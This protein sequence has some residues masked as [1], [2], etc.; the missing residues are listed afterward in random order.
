MKLSTLRA[1]DEAR[2]SAWRAAAS[3]ALFGGVL[4]FHRSQELSLALVGFSLFAAYVSFAIAPL[5]SRRPN[6][7][8][9]GSLGVWL[10]AIFLIAMGPSLN[11]DPVERRFFLGTGVVLFSLVYQ[12]RLIFFAQLPLA[13]L[14]LGLREL[15]LAPSQI[16]SDFSVTWFVFSFPIAVLTMII[17]SSRS[18]SKLVVRNLRSAIE[19]SNQLHRIVQTE[20][21]ALINLRESLLGSVAFAS[22]ASAGGM[23]DSA[24]GRRESIL[25]HGNEPHS[26]FEKLINEARQVFVEFQSQGRSTGKIAGPIRFVFFPPVAGFD[27]NS[28]IAVDI[29][30]LRA[31]LW[32]CLQLAYESLP[33]IGALR[34]EGVI[35]LSMRHG[36]RVIEIAVEDNGRGLVTRNLDAESQLNRLK[37]EVEGL[38]GRFDRVA[39]LGVGSRTSIEL[40][41]LSEKP[42]NSRY[43]ATILHPFTV[44]ESSRAGVTR[45]DSPGDSAQL[46]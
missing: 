27:E 43:R 16:F 2:P 42:A 34:R 26:S 13:A 5:S 44:A 46:V 19:V 9:T 18:K 7:L 39:R 30:G 36:F 11:L 8:P 17:R 37:S 23:S 25:G 41:I 22:D 40:R 29:A 4:S 1:F 20:T 12:G 15:D 21:E 14:F 32:A 10:G 31:G 33:E 6:W 28:Q 3:A 45:A 38:G 24:A 35:R